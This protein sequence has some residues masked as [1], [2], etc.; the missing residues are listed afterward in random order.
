MIMPR[1]YESPK[2]L[3]FFLKLLHFFQA[4][5]QITLER[6]SGFYL[7]NI[8]SPSISIALTEFT[9][10]AI[11]LQSDA[12]LQLSFTCLL[13]FTMFQNIVASSLPNSSSNPPLLIVYL[14]AM[15]TLILIAIFMQACLVHF[16]HSGTSQQ[17]N[18][19]VYK[20]FCQRNK[21]NHV[22]NME[23]TL[24]ILDKFTFFFFTISFTVI[25]VIV[26][27]IIPVSAI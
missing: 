17:F 18:S 11:P 4:I 7:L 25:L 6:K 21:E 9:T 3:F 19:L 26:F 16:S 2:T 14:T 23:K 8:I 20:L 1:F 10:W 27:V 22:Q 15:T 24:K 12:R 5:F 13:S